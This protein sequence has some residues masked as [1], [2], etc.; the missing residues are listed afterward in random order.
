VIAKPPVPELTEEVLFRALEATIGRSLVRAGDLT[1]EEVYRKLAS[2]IVGQDEV[3]RELASAFVGG[4][5]GWRAAKGPRGRWLF[6][7]PTGVGKTETARLLARVLGGGERE[8]LL[9]IDCN[10]LQGSGHDSGPAQNTL[11]GSPPGYRDHGPG[12]LSRIRDMPEC[13]VLFDEIEKADPGVGEIVLQ[14]LHE[15]RVRDATDAELDFRRAFIVF[16]TN[17]GAVYDAGRRSLGFGAEGRAPA[18][19]APSIDEESVIAHLKSMGLGEEFFGRHLRYFGF[20]GLSPEGARIILER[21]LEGLR[22]QAAGRGYELG[23]DPALVEHLAR[24]WQ[25]RFG[26]RHLTTI[27]RH[28][29][30]E[31]LSIADAQ[32]ELRG[33]RRIRLE[34]MQGAAHAAHVGVATRERREETLVIKLA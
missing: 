2:K 32:G 22:E 33:V 26:V 27:L 1:E 18:A 13:I 11:L 12:L 3:L 14:V 28:R 30:D 5:G 4:L 31:H 16:T 25:P 6:A 9:R 7:G 19:E 10:T 21:Q 29:I 17:A 20:Q 8:A 24:Q 34:P 23:W 15:G